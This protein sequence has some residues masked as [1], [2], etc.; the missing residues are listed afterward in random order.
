MTDQQPVSPLQDFVD[1]IPVAATVCSF[2]ANE[3]KILVANKLH[4][5]LTGYTAS[6]LINQSPR[7]FKGAKTDVVSASIIKSELQ[8]YHFC[9]IPVLNYTKQNTPYTITLTICGAVI[10]GTSYYVALKRLI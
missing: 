9:S 1:K 7:I 8:L 6:E 2:D 4:D 10:N 5:Q 3:P